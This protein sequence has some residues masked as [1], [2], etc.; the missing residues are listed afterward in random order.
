MFLNDRVQEM[1]YGYPMGWNESTQSET[2]GS[3]TAHINIVDRFGNIVSIT[4]T[5]EGPF[6]ARIAV[7]ECGFFLNNELT[8]MV[9]N[10]RVANGAQ[11][12][13]RKRISAINLY[14]FKDSESYG[15]KRPR[16]SISPMIVF[17]HNMRYVSIGGE[18]EPVLLI[19]RHLL[20]NVNIQKAINNAR[21]Y[22]FNLDNGQLRFEE[23]IWENVNDNITNRLVNKFGYD[24]NKLLNYSY[25][26]CNGIVIDEY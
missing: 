26:S 5:I 6:G 3:G 20:Y 17:K 22:S 14:G 24:R 9:N 21:M 16:S 8:G 1:P 25:G 11:G 18:E 12:G 4:S 15:G 23:L 2:I 13:K 10:T 19:S 7:D